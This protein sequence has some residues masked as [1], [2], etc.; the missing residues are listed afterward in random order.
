ML[1]F[2]FLTGTISC[3]GPLWDHLP[4]WFFPACGGWWHSQPDRWFK[5][6]T[7]RIWW[8]SSWRMCCWNAHGSNSCSGSINLQ[9]LFML[10]DVCSIALFNWPLCTS[11]CVLLFI[12]LWWPVSS[13]RARNQSQ[14]RHGRSNQCL[15]LHHRC[16]PSCHLLWPPA[17]HRRAHPAHHPM[18]L[19]ARSTTAPCPSTTL[20]STNTL[21]SISTCRLPTH[22]VA[23]PSLHTSRTGMTL[24]WRWCQTNTAQP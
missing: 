20:A 11:T 21:T 16:L 23:G 9:I 1:C 8:T 10:A 2:H 6:R 18:T 14:L 15:L 4:I 12:R 7:C 3:A 19:A 24:T 22:L 5:C 13:Q 17:L